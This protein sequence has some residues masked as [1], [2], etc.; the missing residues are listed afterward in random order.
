M[1]VDLGPEINNAI[2]NLLAASP[3]TGLE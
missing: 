3:G 1:K 2:Q